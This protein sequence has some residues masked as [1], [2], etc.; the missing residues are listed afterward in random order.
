MGSIFVASGGQKNISEG[1]P[2]PFGLLEIF[3]LTG[4]V[5]GLVEHIC[6]SNLDMN[7]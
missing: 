4:I 6:R 5:A 2:L 7:S 1:N 3:F